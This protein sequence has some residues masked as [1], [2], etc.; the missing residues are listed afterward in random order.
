MNI[1]NKI[2]E[3]FYAFFCALAPATPQELKE[4]YLSKANSREVL[5]SRQRQWRSRRE[6]LFVNR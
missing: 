6:S 2:G 5:K 3:A 4:K 1:L